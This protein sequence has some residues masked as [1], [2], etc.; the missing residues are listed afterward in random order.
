MGYLSFCT[1]FLIM[2]LINT[3]QMSVKIT[4]SQLLILIMHYS[5]TVSLVC[6]CYFSIATG[7]SSFLTLVKEKK[8][9]LSTSPGKSNTER[10]TTTSSLVDSKEPEKGVS[11]GGSCIFNTDCLI[12]PPKGV[13]LNRVCSCSSSFPVQVLRRVLACS[14]ARFLDEPCVYDEQCQYTTEFTECVTGSCK[15][16]RGFV[17]E[18][19]GFQQVCY[20]EVHWRD[21]CLA[22]AQCISRGRGD[23]PLQCLRGL[24]DCPLGYVFLETWSN[25]GCFKEAFLGDRCQTDKQCLQSNTYCSLTSR[26]CTCTSDYYYFGEVC[27]RRPNVS[28]I[29]STDDPLYA[30]AVAGGSVIGLAFLFAVGFMKIWR[31]RQHNGENSSGDLS[32]SATVEDENDKPPSYEEAVQTICEIYRISGSAVSNNRIESF[33]VYSADSSLVPTQ[34]VVQEDGTNGYIHQSILEELTTGGTNGCIH[35]A[36]L[37][38]STT[39]DTNGCIHQDI[40]EES[41]TDGTNGCIHQDILEESTT[42]GTNGCIYQVAFQE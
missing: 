5:V 39:D 12:L 15:C 7:L 9:V 31:Y 30:L 14:K 34:N 33:P 27:K 19:F 35:Q 38:E 16:R 24:C 6:L 23:I 41:T 28:K 37:E 22:N 10:G 3:D 1:Q 18:V 17:K 40:L 42:H 2:S 4:V 21:H 25:S 29:T 20:K 32:A 26:L 11:L 13:C 8:Q 36:I